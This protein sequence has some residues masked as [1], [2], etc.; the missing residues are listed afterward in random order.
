MR[1]LG[2]AV[3]QQVPDATQLVPPEVVEA[4]RD[5]EDRAVPA[6]ECAAGVSN[7]SLLA[8][9]AARHKL[10]LL[11]IQ[12]VAQADVVK[13]G[14]DEEQ[15]VRR[16]RSSLGVTSGGQLWQQAVAKELKAGVV[17]SSQRRRGDAMKRLPH[18]WDHAGNS[19]A[20]V[21]PDKHSA[22]RVGAVGGLADE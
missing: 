21:G 19:A 13:V 12:Q 8:V 20:V 7:I 6:E 16:G 15:G 5:E 4:L 18:R 14:R 22:S 17:S 3:E 1:V 9:F 11:S 2:R 10:H